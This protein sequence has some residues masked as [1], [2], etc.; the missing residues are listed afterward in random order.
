MTTGITK[1]EI[2]AALADLDELAK[3]EYGI[4]LEEVLQDNVQLDLGVPR[5]EIRLQRLT[6]I[7]LKRPF[8]KPEKRTE[9]SETGAVR[10]WKWQDSEP[11]GASSTHAKELDIINQLRIP[12]SWNERKP[13][14]GS[15]DDDKVS[16]SWNQFTDDVDHE[17]GLFKVLILYADDQLKGRPTRP[18]SEYTEA[19]ESRKLEAGLDLA[20]LIFDAAITAPLAGLLGVPT[21]V[22]GTVLVGARFGYRKIIDPSQLRLGDS[23]S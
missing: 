23:Y 9:P 7:V 3:D 5:A 4:T 20:T 22:V 10:S 19:A 21:L 2:N 6:G 12:G 1:E 13:L 11:G 15:S 14:T 16:L 18:L 17:R 8:A